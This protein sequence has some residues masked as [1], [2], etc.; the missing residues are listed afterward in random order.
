MTEVFAYVLDLFISTDLTRRE[1]LK[2]FEEDK[3]ELFEFIR[4]IV[5]DKG[6]KGIKSVDFYDALFKKNN[7]FLLE[8]IVDLLLM[9]ELQ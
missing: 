3:L 4:E 2:A 6:V 8:Y 1:V 5:G 9:E 7:E